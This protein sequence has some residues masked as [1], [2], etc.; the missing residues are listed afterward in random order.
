MTGEGAGSARPASARHCHHIVRT[1]VIASLID[2][3]QPRPMPGDS[4]Q[5]CIYRYSA[6]LLEHVIIT[7]TCAST[8]A[9]DAARGIY[10]AGSVT[11][12]DNH[13]QF[14]G[15]LTHGFSRQPMDEVAQNLAYRM[16]ATATPVVANT[17]SLLTCDIPF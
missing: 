4:L 15:S 11:N 7:K 3:L 13:G 8:T 2:H 12:Q 6:S 9:C 17:I 1:I 16:V 14:M 10:V 5:L